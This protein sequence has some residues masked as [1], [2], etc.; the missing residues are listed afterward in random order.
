MKLSRKEFFHASGASLGGLLVAHR[1]PRASKTGLAM[2]Y[3][4]TLCVGCRACQNACKDWNDLPR[5]S[6]EPADLYSTPLGLAAEQWNLIRLAERGDAWSF[7]SYQCHHCAEASCVAVCP[8]GAAHHENEFVEINEQWCIGC[9]YCVEACPFGVPHLSEIT[10]TARK[11]TFCIDRV[12][13]GERGEHEL[14]WWTPSNWPACAAACPTGA[15]TWG[16]RDD[17]LSKAKQ[18]VETLKTSGLPDAYLYGE[19][20]L[21]GLGKLSIH[22]LPTEVY[23]IPVSPRFAVHNVGFQ[24]LSGIVTAAVIAVVPFWLLSRRKGA[25]EGEGRAAGGGEGT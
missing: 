4:A 7:M 16:Q 20:E 10:G 17:L 11:C 23:G 21:G 15:L 6:N 18:R 3:D 19:A 1:S 2:L 14:D 22:P 13:V 5:E 9:G 8:T 25:T 24:W 12:G